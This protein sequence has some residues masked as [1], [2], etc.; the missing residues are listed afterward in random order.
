MFKEAGFPS[1]PTAFAAASAPGATTDAPPAIAPP[2]VCLVC[3]TRERRAARRTSAA[4]AATPSCDGPPAL[5]A[6]KEGTM[7]SKPNAYIV[8]LY[9]TAIFPPLT[10]PGPR[11]APHSERAQ[12]AQAS[13]ATTIS[14]ERLENSTQPNRAEPTHGAR[15]ISGCLRQKHDVLADVPWHVI[16]RKPWDRR[17]PTH[18]CA[19]PMACS[20]ERARQLM[21]GSRPKCEAAKISAGS[22]RP[23]AHREWRG[24]RNWRRDTDLPSRYPSNSWSHGGG[25]GEHGADEKVQGAIGGRCAAVRC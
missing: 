24:R 8:R 18:A 22:P 3:P 19:N 4:A 5:L 11:A 23:R 15:H 6:R 7:P 20:D 12:R 16:R 9:S 17:T 14:V 25:G 1:G 21:E 2:T 10:D 13:G